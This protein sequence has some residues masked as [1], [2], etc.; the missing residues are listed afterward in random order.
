M[1]TLAA[2]AARAARHAAW[3]LMFISLHG[4]AQWGGALEGLGRWGEQLQRDNAE[5]DRER[6]R[7]AAQA[8]R[9]RLRHEIQLE[10]QRLEHARQLR[11]EQQR[12]V[13]IAL[14]KKQAEQARRELEM[15]EEVN[16]ATRDARDAENQ[17]AEIA[18]AKMRV[19]REHPG[20]EE[21]VLTPKF[22]SWKQAQPASVQRLADS[23]RSDDAILMLDLYKKDTAKQ[24]KK[25]R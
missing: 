18:Q 15:R 4:S 1:N 17:R 8:E 12:Q 11:V 9:D 20:W 13:E 24:S 22:T 14:A 5:A 21:L 7:A 19:E 23:P 3:A 25:K 2:P 10:M 6:A 16:R